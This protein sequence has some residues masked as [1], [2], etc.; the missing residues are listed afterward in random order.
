MTRCICSHGDVETLWR[1]W[2]VTL[3]R[4][5]V[6][7]GCRAGAVRACPFAAATANQ[8]GRRSPW[9]LLHVETSEVFAPPIRSLDVIR[10][11]LL[12]PGPLLVRQPNEA[13]RC[14]EPSPL[15][16]P[17]YLYVPLGGSRTKLFNIWVVFLFSSMFFGL[18]RAMTGVH[19]T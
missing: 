15:L 14:L 10:F 1:T 5:V 8:G 9:V 11:P 6:R 18:D 16:V 19:G 7:C 4:W 17:R 2:N 12:T 3:Y 13:A